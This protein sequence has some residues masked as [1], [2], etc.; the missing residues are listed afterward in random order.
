MFLLRHKAA[1]N[2]QQRPFKVLGRPTRVKKNNSEYNKEAKGTKKEMHKWQ[3]EKIGENKKN[4]DGN[5]QNINK[6]DY[7]E[8]NL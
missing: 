1:H 5:R 4:N 6:I 3:Q 7:Y 2:T 8:K